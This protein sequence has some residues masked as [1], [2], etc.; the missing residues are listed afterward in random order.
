VNYSVNF[1]SEDGTGGAVL[2][3][4]PV[5]VNGLQ[6]TSAHTITIEFKPFTRGAIP[7]E[8]EF[9]RVSCAA[10]QALH[11]ELG[12][13]GA[14]G[15]PAWVFGATDWLTDAALQLQEKGADFTDYNSLADFVHGWRRKATAPVSPDQSRFHV[16]A[17]RTA[18]RGFV[19]GGLDWNNHQ[20]KLF[21]AKGNPVKEAIHLDWDDME[22]GPTIDSPDLLR[23]AIKQYRGVGLIEPG[24]PEMAIRRVRLPGSRRPLA[25]SPDLK[26]TATSARGGAELILVRLEDREVVRVLPTGPAAV[27][28]ARFSPDGRF[29]ASGTATGVLQVWD[30]ESGKEA[31]HQQLEARFINAIDFFPDG[32]RVAVGAGLGGEGGLALLALSDGS[33]RLTE[34]KSLPRSVLHLVIAEKGE[35]IIAVLPAGANPFLLEVRGG[36]LEDPRE[37][38]TEGRQPVF[39]PGSRPATVKFS[40]GKLQI[41]P[42]E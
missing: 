24:V 32:R 4:E 33:W 19:W 11:E 37:L 14:V 27:L 41:R 6:A 35:R 17:A 38:R 20:F 36:R 8:R 15:A 18:E 42:I 3:F 7:S 34:Q 16:V 9:G 28:A 10:N 12:A 29:L 31:Y 39:L 5:T 13:A 23:F 2:A 26:T 30:V 1:H 40:E 21:D 25:V 22:T